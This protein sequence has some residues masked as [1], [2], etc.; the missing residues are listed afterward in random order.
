MKRKN[1]FL[2]LLFM[3]ISFSVFAQSFQWGGRF[4]GTG[5]DVIKEMHV[6][7]A[8][9]SYTTGYF[10]DTADF[11]ISTENE[12]NLTANGFYDIFVQKTNT[13]GEFVWAVSIGGELFDYG[14]GISTDDQG[15]VYVTGYFDETTDFDPGPGEFNLTSQGGGDVFI[16]KLDSNGEFIWA[17]TVGGTGYEEPTSIGIDE[18]GNVYI[19]GYIYETMDFD[20]GADE[21]L[22]TSNGAAD[23][24]LLILDSEGDFVNVFSYGG[25]D[26]ELSLE[27]TVKSSTEI[28]ISGFFN[29]TT[30]LDPRPFEE[31]LVT[32]SNEGS[33]G[34]VMQIDNTGTIINYATTQGGN[35]TTQTVATDADNNLYIGGVFDGTVNFDPISGTS[36]FTFTSAVAFNSF[37]LKVGVDGTVAWARQIVADDSNFLYDMEVG[38]DGAVY[39]AG[40]FGGSTD[41]NPSETEDFILD[42]VSENASDAF[43]LVLNSDGNFMDAYQFG[44]VN[45]IDT[46]Q[47]DIDA[48]DAV[49]LSAQFETTVDINPLPDESEETMA[50]DFRDNYLFKFGEEALGITDFD[51]NGIRLFPNPT[52]DELFLAGQNDLVGKEYTVYNMLGQQV[53]NGVLSQRQRI[54]VKALNRGVYTLM[55]SNTGSF[56]FIKE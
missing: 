42:K 32:A 37:I 48:N 7:A 31:L 26:Q 24:F 46:H 6:D 18:L 25:E 22:V 39:G 19:L 14:T 47:I 56:K 54:A 21:Y 40:F 2:L 12:A 13:E 43:M 16:L 5:E 41:F 38:S 30:D 51:V 27:M 9:N 52:E 10:T 17:K 34:Y 50:A 11:D 8:G 3:S 36:D 55:V 53:A 35:V 15:N 1:Y 49:Y 4:G 29:G 33:A 23:T 20:P 44:G 45:F 28:F